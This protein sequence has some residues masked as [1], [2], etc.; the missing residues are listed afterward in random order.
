[1]DD[2]KKIA[3]LAALFIVMIGVGAFQF[4]KSGSPEAPAPKA[5]TEPQTASAKTEKVASETDPSGKQADEHAEKTENAD[6]A[7]KAEETKTEVDPAL[8]AAARLGKRDPF[9][10]RQ[11]DKS[12]VRPDNT[13]APPTIAP[14]IQRPKRSISGQLP[15]DPTKVGVLPEGGG[16]AITPGGKLPN[17]D[18][19]PYTV[20]GTILGD[21]PCVVVTDTEGKQKVVPVGG[22]IDGDSQVLSISKGKVTVRHRG[23]TKTFSVGGMNPSE[24][25]QEGN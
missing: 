11:W 22:S 12:L 15:F 20:S 3:A 2:K 4:I 5:A 21:R 6:K 9:D 18:E 13:P 1:M 24:T 8:V 16:P 14:P 25:K 23:K 7:D 19:F 17:L 10:G